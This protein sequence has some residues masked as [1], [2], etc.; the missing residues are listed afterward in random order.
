MNSAGRVEF[1]RGD[2]RVYTDA[3]DNSG[4]VDC[5]DHEVNIKVLL[6]SVIADGEL[7]VVSTRLEDAAARLA[8]HRQVFLAEMQT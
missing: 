8:L 1:A 5:S 7:T 6:G 3:I 2:G 4:G